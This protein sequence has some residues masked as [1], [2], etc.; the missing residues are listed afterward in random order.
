VSPVEWR[1]PLRPFTTTKAAILLLGLE[2]ILILDFFFLDLLFVVVLLWLVLVD[3][4]Y[5]LASSS[6]L[7]RSSNN[8]SHIGNL[9]R[10]IFLI[11]VE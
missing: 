6:P 5:G 11:V 2:T 4:I 3:V 1:V 8:V 9:L 10:N 7:Q